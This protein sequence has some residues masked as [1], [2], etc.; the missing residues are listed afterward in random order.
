MELDRHRQVARVWD[1]LP[2]FRAVAEYGSL[3]RAGLALAISPSALSRSI[4]LLEETLG[5]LLFTRSAAGVTLTPQGEHL[6]VAVREAMRR[7]HDGMPAPRTNRLRAGSCGPVLGRVLSAAAATS[8][9]TW[10][11]ALVELTGEPGA[12]L[13]RGDLDVVLA[14]APAPEAGLQGTPLP[15]IEL[16]LARAPGGTRDRVASL[17]APEFEWPGADV[18]T[19]QLDALLAVARELK[20]TVSL[21]RRD[22]PAEWEVLE[23]LPRVPVWFITRVY[24]RGV[25][26][27]LSTLRGEL[28]KRLSPGA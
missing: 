22:C 2:A 24:E 15:P 28:E 14:H 26:D 8:L 21:P 19:G 4:K 10:S 7:I 9:A 16:V 17:A 1:W 11:L 13:L 12:A 27:F 5:L 23:A 25:P 18:T 6:L 3:Q 20:L